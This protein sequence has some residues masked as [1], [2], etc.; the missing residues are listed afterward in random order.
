MIFRGAPKGT[1]TPSQLVK[2]QL[3]YQL[4]Y[5]RIYEAGRIYVAVSHWPTLT[6]T[7]ARHTFSGSLSPVGVYQPAALLIGYAALLT[8]FRLSIAFCLRRNFTG[9]SNPYATHTRSIFI[10]PTCQNR[11]TSSRVEVCPYR[12]VGRGGND[13][14][15]Y[16]FSDRR[17]DLISYRPI[18]R[19]R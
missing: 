18:W 14:P 11:H 15:S 19:R 7:G 17:S 10:L 4:S 8:A 13:P 9:G 12:L 6:N 1:R 5:R 3:L 16:G 2:S